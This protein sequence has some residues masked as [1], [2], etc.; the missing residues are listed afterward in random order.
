[1]PRKRGYEQIPFAERFWNKVDK[2][3][4]NDACWTWTSYIN[5]RTGY[6]QMTKGRGVLLLAH[7][8]S[9]EL[10]YGEIPNGKCVC[11]SCDNRK[12]CNPSHLWTGTSRDN[13]LDA[14]KKGRMSKPPIHYG[15]NHPLTKITDDD[16][17]NIR[18]LR[19]NGVSSNVLAHHFGLH[20]TTIINIDHRQTWGHI[21]DE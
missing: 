13:I 2:S 4:G 15:I 11:H 7:R 12:C 1:M 21:K 16:V 19:K 10:A 17:R 8:V 5:P 18:L 14:V 3:G 20:K 6:G 9:Y